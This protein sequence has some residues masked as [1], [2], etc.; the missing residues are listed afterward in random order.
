LAKGQFDSSDLFIELGER[1]LIENGYMAYIVPDSIFNP[2]K[3]NVR[4]FILSN[5]E[6]CFIS[7]LGEKFFRNVNRAC[8]LLVLR[9]CKPSSSHKIESF[10]LTHEDRKNI[11]AGKS[12]LAVVCNEKRI[13]I[14]QTRFSKNKNFQFDI[15]V[16]SRDVPTFH[17]IKSQKNILSSY[18][19]SDRGVE[20]SKSGLVMKCL[21]CKKY[22]PKSKKEI[23]ICPHCRSNLGDG[24]MLEDKI[25]SHYLKTHILKD[26]YMEKF[27]KVYFNQDKLF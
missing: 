15:E 7:R 14:P 5:F 20:L 12:S 25:T 22:S 13:Y 8:V 11:F 1:L 2:D 19:T 27:R 3:E 24:D 16:E 6:I 17:K 9:K 26:K 4:K 21:F 10:R 18:L 23:L